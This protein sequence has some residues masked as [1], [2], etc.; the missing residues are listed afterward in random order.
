MNSMKTMLSIHPEVANRWGIIDT[1][2]ISG[3]TYLGGFSVSD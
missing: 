3:K 1:D 2:N